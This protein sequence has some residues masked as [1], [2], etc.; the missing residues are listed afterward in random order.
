MSKTGSAWAALLALGLAGCD[1]GNLWRDEADRVTE[2]FP[3][4]RA[5]VDAKVQLDK[6]QPAESEPGRRLARE[7]ANRIEARALACLQGTELSTFDSADD[8]RRK[9]PQACFDGADSELVAWLGTYR[10]RLMAQ[11]PAVSELPADAPK[12]IP[13]SIRPTYVSFAAAAPVVAVSDGMNVE[14]LDFAADR[15]VHRSESKERRIRA[16]EMSPNGRVYAAVADGISLF[17]AVTGD[18]LAAYPNHSTMQ[19]LT[20]LGILLT[21]KD[22]GDLE[23]LDLGSGIVAPAR[24]ISDMRGR[25]VALAG[26]PN[27]FVLA[28]HNRAAQFELLQDRQGIRIALLV[29]SNGSG[30]GS[31]GN[32]IAS[33]D[34]KVLAGSGG[35]I[36]LVRLDPQTLTAVDTKFE[37]FRVQG[38]CAL[39]DPNELL[40]QGYVQ[41]ANRG[42]HGMLVYYLDT[43]SVSPIVDEAVVQQL[44]N[45]GGCPARAALLNRSYVRAGNSLMSLANPPRAARYS[46]AAIGTYFAELVAKEREA[47]PPG[48]AVD[49]PGGY[50]VGNDTGRPVRAAAGAVL[51]DLPKDAQV[52]AVGVYEAEGAPTRKFREAGVPSPVDV[53]VRKSNSPIVLVVSSYEPVI[54][55]VTIMP[56]AKVSAIL[57]SG[58]SE[59][60]KVMGAGDTRVVTM[61]QSYA[62]EMGGQKHLALDQEVVRWTGRRIQSLQGRYKARMFTVQGI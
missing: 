21:K 36:G 52:H 56:G 62:Y 35:N 9:L 16:L 31:F 38:V 42:A 43:G 55:R 1:V 24:G 26:T 12:S 25:A 45:S 6:L 3:V 5:V 20:P 28:G 27:R 34:G 54:W 44:R 57:L 8:V 46:A 61:G 23:L 33:A 51:T 32:L 2:A 13:T 7:Y 18:R 48:Y 53:I 49:A 39:D 37:G 60:S 10:L 50:G 59:L 17:D 19:W 30:S 11:L 47:Y 41:G 29:Q 14:I 58:N 15:S 4:S 40:L 22:N